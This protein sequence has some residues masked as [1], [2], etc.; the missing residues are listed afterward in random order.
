MARH[1][2]QRRSAAHVRRAA[3]GTGHASRHTIYEVL[4]RD[5]A[6][7]TRLLEEVE[8]TSDETIRT[9][10]NLFRRLRDQLDAH[11]RAEETVLYSQLKPAGPTRERVLQS[12]EEHH[13]VTVLLG[14]LD[15]M[16]KTHER[17]IP[18][19]RL[20]RDAV[21]HH[22]ELEESELFAQ[23]QE[24]IDDET[25]RSLGAEMLRQKEAWLEIDHRSPA[26]A[27]LIRGVT[28]IA[29]RLPFGGGMV[30]VTVNSNPRTMMQLLEAVQM[31]TPQRGVTGAVYR[32]LTWPVTAPMSML[33]GRS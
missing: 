6:G 9:R 28:Q 3:N 25:A 19:L 23:A 13:L 11:S 24:I 20:L 17:W 15:A 1:N 7:I 27:G 32:A 33:G 2:G 21:H 31:L 30:A 5:H 14:E 16:P 10:E 18:K 26:V 12:I 8:T 4:R 22:V 29:E